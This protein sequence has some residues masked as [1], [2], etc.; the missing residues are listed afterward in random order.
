MGDR[1]EGRENDAVS[2]DCSR[3]ACCA[4]A[5]DPNPNPL[6][7][8]LRLA[9]FATGLAMALVGMIRERKFKLLGAWLGTW[10]VFLSIARYLTCSRCDGYGKMCYSFYIGK[11]TSLVLPRTEGKDVGPVGIGLE[12]ACLGAIFWI[13]VVAMRGDRRLLARYLAVM[14]LTLI[15][16]V[17]HSCRWCARNSRQAWKDACPVHRTWKKVL[18][19]S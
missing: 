16:Q 10:G 13:P 4:E 7:M 3:A 5:C 17:F 6:L 11:Y 2:T 15:G 9:A 14:Q 18:K 19:I 1:T 12:A 8:A